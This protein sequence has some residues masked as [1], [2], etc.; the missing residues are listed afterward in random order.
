M[1]TLV[2]KDFGTLEIESRPDPHPGQNEVRLRIIATGIC[3]SDIHGFTGKNGRRSPGQIMGH[4]SVGR[5]DALGDGSSE[6]G[7]KVGDLVTFNPV[8][9]PEEDLAAYEGREQHSPRKRVIGVAPDYVSAFAELMIVPARNVVVLP[10][11]MPASLGALIEPIAVGVHATNRASVRPGD[12]VLVIGGGPIG[13]CVALAAIKCGAAEVIVSELDEGRR[14]LCERLGLKTINPDG[15]DLAGQVRAVWSKL[16]DVAFDAV[17][18]TGTLSDALLSTKLGGTTCLVGMGSPELRLE[19]Y[20]V[21]T[22]ERS[23]VGSFAYSSAEF[24]DAAQWISDGE[25]DFGELISREVPLEQ[26]HDAF[27][28]LAKIDGT[29]GKVLVRFDL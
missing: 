4:E 15:T 19:A 5:I 11:T 29:A 23:V 7:L 18:V 14:A 10:A 8:V 13:Q 17:G 26:A 2:L 22:D 27:V 28:G 12:N 1:R 6:L 25:L 20:R 3:G 21:S 9:I 16:A 24:R